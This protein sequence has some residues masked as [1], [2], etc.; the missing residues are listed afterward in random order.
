MDKKLFS[1]SFI[2]TL[3]DVIITYSNV[4][5]ICCLQSKSAS[6][7]NP[8]AAAAAPASQVAFCLILILNSPILW[9]QDYVLQ[10]IG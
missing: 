4:H 7:P 8:P 5:F 10:K 9:P 1:Q 2:I 6:T 3:D